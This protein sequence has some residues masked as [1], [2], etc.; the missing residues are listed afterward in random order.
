MFNPKLMK[1]ILK[2]NLEESKAIESKL[3]HK[4][5]QVE[6][7]MFAYSKFATVPIEILK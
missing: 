1:F 5:A 7:K 2:N 4:P 6:N 3:E